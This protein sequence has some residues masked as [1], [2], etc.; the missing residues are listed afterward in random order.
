MTSSEFNSLGKRIDKLLNQKTFYYILK[1]VKNSQI[2]ILTKI[3]TF[4]LLEGSSLVKDVEQ[5][6][7]QIEN[8]MN[9]YLKEHIFDEDFNMIP[10]L[11]IIDEYELE[12]KK[13]LE[14]FTLKPQYRD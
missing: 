13:R 3:I 2:R 5:K 9:D 1:G 8:D 7:K 10:F 6:F 11:S 4:E 12:F 14:T